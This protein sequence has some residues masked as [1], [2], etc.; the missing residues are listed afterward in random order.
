MFFEVRGCLCIT[1][2]LMLVNNF[3]FKLTTLANRY[4]DLTLIKVKEKIWCFYM[5]KSI[6]L[7]FLWSIITSS[8]HPFVLPVSSLLPCWVW[9]VAGG[10]WEALSPGA[11]GQG[12][13][14]HQWWLHFAEDLGAK[15][16][17]VGELPEAQGLQVTRQSCHHAQQQ[18]RKMLCLDLYVGLLDMLKIHKSSENLSCNYRVPGGRSTWSQINIIIELRLLS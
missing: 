14:G 9:G 15:A 8:P 4:S 5:L 7:S 17:A 18:L 13:R 10:V 11:R 16:K 2:V 3:N 6:T 12:Q 1:F